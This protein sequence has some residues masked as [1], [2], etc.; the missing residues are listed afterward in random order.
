[1]AWTPRRPSAHA[2]QQRDESLSHWVVASERTTLGLPRQITTVKPAWKSEKSTK[3]FAFYRFQTVV[4][5]NHSLVHPLFEYDDKFPLNIKKVG[6]KGNYRT[7]RI[8]TYIQ[9]TLICQTVIEK[10]LSNNFYHNGKTVESPVH[11]KQNDAGCRHWPF[12]DQP[13]EMIEN[14]E[15]NKAIL[16]K[17]SNEFWQ[18]GILISSHTSFTQ[19]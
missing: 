18:F 10:V 3:I 13:C 16:A 19:N 7:N 5:I 9:Q 14:G 6:R 11:E 4:K 17:K 15:Y 1:M 8:Y 2:Q 12:S